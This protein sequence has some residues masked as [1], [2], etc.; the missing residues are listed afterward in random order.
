MISVS[1]DILYLA[2]SSVRETP[3]S[4]GCSILFRFHCATDYLSVSNYTS[5][6]QGT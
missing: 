5:V 3:L 2:A 4:L 1:V 6:E